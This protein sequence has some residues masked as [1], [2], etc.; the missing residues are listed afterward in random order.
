MSQ[1]AHF[2]DQAVAL[3]GDGAAL[4]RRCKP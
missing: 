3:A 4:S 2:V 1:A